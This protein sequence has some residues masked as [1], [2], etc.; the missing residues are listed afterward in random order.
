MSKVVH[1]ELLNPS[2]EEEKHNYFG[3]ISAIYGTF[4]A[5]RLGISKGSLWNYKIT[6]ERSY[7]NDQCIIRVGGC[8][9]KPT[10]RGNLKK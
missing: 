5:S 10:C 7:S 1:V 2:E 6:E 3:S 4:T 8:K 9:R